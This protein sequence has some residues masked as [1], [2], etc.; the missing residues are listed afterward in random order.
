MSD[1]II[2]LMMVSMIFLMLGISLFF[3]GHKVFAVGVFAYILMLLGFTSLVL[4][5]KYVYAA[6]LMIVWCTLTIPSSI[7]SSIERW[8]NRIL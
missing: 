2:Y 1:A 6:I 5:D 7:R 3:N 8:L 4:Y